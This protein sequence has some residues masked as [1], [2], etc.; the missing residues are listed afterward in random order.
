VVA[1][2]KPE[3]SVK[4]ENTGELCLAGEQ[5][6]EGYWFSERQPFLFLASENSQV[7][8]YPTGDQVK[9]DAEGNFYYLGR[10]DDQVKINGYRVD[11]IEVENIVREHIPD[12]GNVAA[13]IEVGESL[14]QLV[15]FVE[16]YRK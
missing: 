12:C 5:V 3:S 13:K 2:I 14:S 7:K 9:M 8:F 16:N 11:L 6:M 15:V 10:N 1:Y 4:N